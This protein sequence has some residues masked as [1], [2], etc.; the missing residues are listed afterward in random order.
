MTVNEIY[1]EIGQSLMNYI[2]E[3]WN[4]A[5]LEITR[6]EKS[7]GWKGV[8]V[9]AQGVQKDI[10]IWEYSLNPKIIQELHSI[11]TEGG[12]NKWNKLKFVLFPAGKFE[13]NFIWDQ[14][15]QDAVDKANQK[16]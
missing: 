8:Y 16:V 14:E 5:I 9:D 4:K 12:K 13:V 2:S 1:Q 10:D 6:V 7:V 11:T 15:Y 3:K